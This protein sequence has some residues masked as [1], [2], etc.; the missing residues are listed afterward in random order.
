[1]DTYTVYILHSIKLDKFYTGYTGMTV[2]ERLSKHLTG[3]KGFTGKTEDWEIIYQVSLNTKKEA[4]DLEKRIK[5]RG[6]RR[7]LEGRNLI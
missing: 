4:I 2:E 5:R 1:M 7:F 6:A 3:A